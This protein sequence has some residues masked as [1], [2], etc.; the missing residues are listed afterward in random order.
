M[1][2]TWSPLIYGSLFILVDPVTRGYRG[3]PM[4]KVK[5]PW[6][7]ANSIERGDGWLLRGIK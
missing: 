3:K 2:P 6:A 5:N 4:N 7:G 1:L